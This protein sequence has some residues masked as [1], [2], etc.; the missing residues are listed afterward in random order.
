MDTP[1][2]EPEKENPMLDGRGKDILYRQLHG[3]EDNTG[4]KRLN[5]LSFAAPWDILVI[6]M[7]SI[8]AVAAGAANPLLTV[9][10]GQLA[11][12][13]AGFVQG[14]VS[15]DT[16]RGKTNQFAL[17]YVYLA[18]AE[19]FLIYTSTVGFYYT[20]ERITQRIRQ[21]YLKATI[22]Q[23]MAF[24]DT[25]GAGI[26]TNHIASD[27]NQIQEALTS[28]LSMALTAAANF[29]AAFVI[30]FIMSWKL[31]FVL[32]SVFV[33]MIIITYAITPFAIDYGKISSKCYGTGSS[34]AQEAIGAI[35]DVTVCGSQ[36]Q[37]CDRYNL[38]LK[39]AE[40]SG[41]KSRSLIAIM[42]GW[43]NAM[44]CFTYALGFYVGA[45][46]LIKGYVG[47][48]A[49]TSATLAIVNGAFAVVRIIPTAEAFVNGMASASSVFET[50]SRK[51]PQDPYSKDGIVPDAIIGTFELKDVGLVYPS[52]PDVPVLRGVNIDIPA[53]KT[54]ALVGLSGCG[55]SSIFG[56][57]E[58]FYEPT[59]GTI[60]LD[61]RDVQDLNLRWLRCQM[62]YVGQE[63]VLFSTTV[64]ENIRQGLESSELDDDPQRIRERVIAAAKL[65]NAHDFI[66][67][68]PL[69]YDTEVGE[70][71]KSLS[72]GQRQ[73]V[74]IA[75]AIVAEPSVLLLDEA[76]SALDTTSERIVQV[77]LEAAAQNRTTIV[78]AHRLSTIRNADNIIVM[79]AGQV[80]EQGTHQQLMALHGAYSKLVEIQQVDGSHDT[81]EESDFDLGSRET[82]QD[83]YPA[84]KSKKE[85][86]LEESE[87]S[88]KSINDSD[89]EPV[90]PKPQSKPTFWATIKM[91]IQLNK[92]EWLF[93]F[94]GLL[95]AM[96]AGFGL[97]V[98]SVFFAKILDAF[99]IPLNESKKL[100]DHVNIWALAF[101]LIGVYCFFIWLVNGIF[102]AYA[103]EKLSRRVRYLCLR[104]IL[105]QNIGYF[106]DKHHSTGNMSSML[107]SSAADLAGLGG[108]VIGS[109]LTFTF[110]IATGIIMSV[111]IGWKLGLICTATIPFT[112][113]L[114][115]VRL[116]FISIFDSKVR[117][118]SQRA[119][120]YASEAVTAIRTVAASGLED[121]VLQSYRTVQLEQA[122]KS[123]PAIL[124]ASALYAASQ[125]VAFLAAALVFWYGSLLLARHEYGLTQFFICFVALIWGSQ[126]AGALFN[127]APD[128]GKAM[129]AASDLKLLFEKEPTIDTWNH[130]GACTEK[131]STKGHL[132]LHNIDFYYPTRLDQPVL[133][134]ISLDI[135]AG[136]FVAL[137]GASG[138][139]KSTI[140][141]LLERFYDP[142]SGTVTLDGQDISKLNI[143]G[144]R[145]LF[146]LVGQEP[147]LYSGTI[148][149]NLALGLS[150]TVSEDEIVQAC[151]DAN[152][153]DFITSL[154]Q[155]LE[156]SVGSS[157]TMLSGGQKQRISIARALLRNPRIL[158]LDE[159]TSALDSESEKLVQDAL[160]RAAESRT[161]V[162]IAHRLSTVQKADII[163]VISE[164]QVVESGSHRELQALG[165]HY[166]SLLQ[167]QGLQ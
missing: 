26:I 125:A 61:G 53:L 105:R 109:I 131:E 12:T 39:D 124:R 151:K 121:F 83:I 167:M 162:A 37:L 24:F 106:D 77:A 25:R 163:Y 145:Q 42:I 87:A 57:L 116:Q 136:K 101:T 59:S 115:W 88:H 97:P 113:V 17:Y 152:I 43:A 74:A 95:S 55:K 54:T 98:Q 33:A 45:R 132:A 149:E 69:G 9:I 2:Q 139:G 8:M 93:L 143:N 67:R 65:A 32:C 4:K 5:P 38:F 52:R 62:G 3:L 70:K 144:Y 120:N 41:I 71:G 130:N 96:L 72:G 153:Y 154:P 150:T 84:V 100:Q 127:F 36:A 117:L 164:G 86:L 99:S 118:S 16:L 46:F 79:S 30:A 40:K 44:P 73:R 114:G 34:L 75:R 56:L 15:G 161:T 22:R 7:S 138:C 81:S 13:F 157:G 91:I 66:S 122:K 51:S 128:I 90:G 94:G 104:H 129:N 119:A 158:L 29:G 156:T 140:L 111:V 49:L 82:L 135:P 60:R 148:R 50:I 76:T 133:R 64:F 102:F 11:S 142:S 155:G 126:I 27:M 85:T 19:F 78:I 112:A 68:L 21:A 58:R 108:A 107:S 159:A 48:S 10:F 146:S 123:L 137:V 20:G 31:A 18:I 166:S 103:T 14:S 63:P 6:V 147:T 80:V 160:Q 28:K 1:S 134:N 165:G 47:I 92:P 141:G 35:R 89:E 23:N 110:T